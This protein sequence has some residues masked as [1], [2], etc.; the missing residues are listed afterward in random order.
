M[1]QMNKIDQE[2]LKLAGVE[3][4]AKKRIWRKIK[5]YF[6]VIKFNCLATYS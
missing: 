6:K 3:Y 4:D 5:Y 1:G 2:Q